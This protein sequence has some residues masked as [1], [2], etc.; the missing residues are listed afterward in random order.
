MADTPDFLTLKS[1]RDRPGIYEVPIRRA[2]AALVALFCLAGLLNVFG[3][4]PATSTAASAAAA[5]KVYAP[6]HVRSGLYY[7]ARFTINAIADVKKATL[8]LDPGW[9]EGQTINTIEPGPINEAS[10]NGKLVL[11]LGHIGAGKVY[12][13]FIQIQVNPTNTGRRSQDVALYDGDTFLTAVDRTI[14]IFP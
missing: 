4:R 13:L 6:K 1:N 2:G 5:L 10:R 14:T 8:V 9:A 12:I 7:E 11:E 3:Q